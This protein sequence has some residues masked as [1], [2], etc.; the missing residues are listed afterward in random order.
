M[1]SLATGGPYGERDLDAD[2]EADDYG[3][4]AGGKKRKVPAIPTG[5]QNEPLEPQVSA[6]DMNA[7]KP[8]LLS[9]KHRLARSTAARACSF[10]KAL[11]L[12]RQAALIMLYLDAQSAIIAGSARLGPKQS[13]LPLVPAFEKLIPSLEDIGVADWAPDKPGWRNEDD[14]QGIIRPAKS[15]EAWRTLYAARRRE[16]SLRRPVIR[17][18]WAPEGSFEFDMGCK[19]ELL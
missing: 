3:L 8:N 5:G 19:G 1:E 17:G 14:G 15:L 2:R 10:R 12:R 7:G 6:T 16:R 9:L 13:A 18:G 4:G 11:F